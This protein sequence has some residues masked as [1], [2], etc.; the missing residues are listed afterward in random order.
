MARRRE[1]FNVGADY[2]VDI[3]NIVEWILK[4]Q[5]ISFDLGGDGC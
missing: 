2:E 4:I 3:V 5:R 1:C